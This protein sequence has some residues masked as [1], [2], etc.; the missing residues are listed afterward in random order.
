MTVITGGTGNDTLTGG[1]DADSISGLAG[2]DTL[3]GA[4]GNDTLVGGAGNDSMDG[5][6][7]ADRFILDQTSGGDTII[8]GE[9]GVDFDVIDAASLAAGNAVRVF[10]TTPEAGTVTTTSGALLATFSQIEQFILSS[11]N[12]IFL[13]SDSITAGTFVDG[14]AG[15]DSISGTGGADTLVGGVGADTLRGGGGADSLSGGADNDLLEG[16][17]GNDTIDG[18]DGDDTIVEG[19]GTGAG[20]RSFSWVNNFDGADPL[21]G[22]SQLLF[23]GPGAVNLTGDA[24]TDRE[25]VF[26]Q[27]N[28]SSQQ[29][30]VNVSPQLLSGERVQS[31]TMSMT[32]DMGSATNSDWVDGFSFSLGDPTSVGF[33][34]ENGVGRGLAV[35]F[36]PLANLIEL[37]WNG[38]P[39]ASVA[40]FNLEN[41]GVGTLTITISNTGL[42]TVQA[43]LSPSPDI[44]ATIPG[45]QWTTTDQSGWQFVFAGRTGSN[46]GFVYMDDVNLN[47]TITTP[48]TT[49]GNDVLSG[50]LG[51]D[52]ISG[53]AGDDTLDGGVGNDSL[54]GGTG[55]D[56]ILGG[57]GNDTLTDS[58]GNDTLDGGAGNDSLSA[59]AGNDS[60]LG[61]DGDDTIFDGV[62]NDTIFGGAG[63]DVIDDAGGFNATSDPTL[64]FGEAG[65]DTLNGTAGGDTLD[66][67]ADDDVLAG[68]DGNDSLTGGTGN[69]SIRADGGSDTLVGGAGNDTLDGGTGDD[70]LILGAGDSA[71]GGTGDDE[72]RFDNT[73]TGTT[74]I[75][76][77]GGEGGEDLTDP[78]NG[79]TGDV[80]DL[81]GLPGLTITYNTLD[82]TWNGLTSES[83]T[84]T[85][86][87]TLGQTVTI[88]FSQIE[89]I[90]TDLD[91][92]VDGTSGNDSIGPGYFDGQGDLIDGWD[93]LNDSIAAGAGDDTV[94]AG[95]GN[96]TIDAGT[97]NDSIDGG[98][99]NDSILAGSG[100]DIL[101]GG[102][103]DDTL[104]DGAG[105]DTVYGGAGNDIIDDQGGINATTDPTLAF[106]EAGNDTI[107]GTAGDDTLDGGADSDLLNGENGNDSLVGGSGNDTLNG[108]SGNDT[109]N[110]GTGNDSLNGGDGD[111]R[112]ILATG[113]GADSISG[114]EAGET[115]GDLLD[116]GALTANVTLTLTGAETGTLV[117]GA[118][119]VSFSAIERILL[120]AGNDSVTGGAGNDSVD[121]G[122]G[123]DTLSGGA[124]NDTLAGGL[125][126]DVLTGGA[127][128]DSLDGGAGDDDLVLGAGDSAT[129]GAGDD[130]FRFDST[131]AGNAT[132][133]VS[134][135]ETGEDLT[136]PTNGGAGDVLDLRGL[137]G[138]DIVWNT[139]DPTW[140]GLRSES[141]T[142][143]YVNSLGQTV[144]IQ[145]SQIERVL[146]DGDGS[147]SGTGG[148][149]S[150][151]PGYA[152]AQGDRVDGWDGAN[153]TILAGAGD[154]TVDAGAGNDSVDGG[155]GNDLL[156]GGAGN[157]TLSGG[158][159]NDTL[160]GG[161]GDALT[162][163]TGDDVFRFDRLAAGTAPITVVGGQ[164]SAGGLGD[165]LSLQGLTSYTATWTNGDKST[166]SGTLTYLNANGDLVTVNFSEIE[167]II[168]FARDTRITTARGDVPVQ[169]LRFGDLILTAD[170]GYQPLRWLAARNLTAAELAAAPN[171]RPIRIRA[172]ALGQG[173]PRRDLTVSPQ[174]RILIRSKV[175]ERMFGNH[176]VLMA[177]KH[178]LALD[179]VET[180]ADCDSVEYW[181]LMCDRHEVILA[182]GT[183]AESLFT[184]PEAMAAIPPECH[185]EL[186]RLF[187]DLAARTTGPAA[188]PFPK[189]AA[190]RQLVH[191]HI[192]NRKP[193][194]ASPPR[195][196]ANAVSAFAAE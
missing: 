105:N 48:P 134:G 23:G 79:G 95:L 150:I 67:G 135:G 117:S 188:R 133:T 32:L 143:T 91:G 190:C 72:F 193:V 177:A 104:I 162:G 24:N 185:A 147:V 12:D 120:G 57:D 5:G 171:L 194:L 4:G 52:T 100:N 113:D 180:V 116:G 43:P 121:A 70:D 51:N 84:A 61:G 1:V 59:G 141:G 189:G 128:S 69:D 119:S 176:E 112:F 40:S 146:T 125:G 126:A 26:V 42:V 8:G 87:N 124:G 83:G 152:D 6:D 167:R 13:G 175:A 178:L 35:R 184:G 181:H 131:L 130:E 82:P 9:T 63:N 142:A 76:I 10:L 75:T 127:G 122:A 30:Q 25:Y 41:R 144:T 108:D 107:F 17:E 68:E 7:G 106:G 37:R 54:D 111:D 132:I 94:E 73:L 115:A 109:L 44:S 154:D 18:G 34:R 159:G 55:N 192:L 173:L 74:T 77:V 157:D 151:G 16:G 103:G 123:N 38:V 156:N 39:F 11:G 62:G 183:E 66:G 153:D 50:G 47:A 90:L 60:I 172:G 160:T 136:D 14:G 3:T 161:A 46:T 64:A 93:G 86:R 170:R 97:G 28:S 145:F 179:G 168:C 80:M 71:A 164:N 155:T 166:R 85:F 53:G 163:G 33:E 27:A 182:E 191:R 36:D 114:G 118:D 196:A 138:I 129:G 137:S 22:A 31:L 148:N 19:G 102:N 149:D 29:A 110:G 101:R 99:G 187:P 92:R 186:R 174:H 158:D 49:G 15:A 65:N 56:S 88:T 89:R 20:T 140:N 195:P 58:A 81:R 165:V 96:D 169:D 78:T 98:D 45:G 139:A 21:L 2:N